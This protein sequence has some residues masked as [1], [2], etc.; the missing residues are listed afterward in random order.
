MGRTRKAKKVSKP[1]AERIAKHVAI[2]KRL[3]SKNHGK[4]PTYTWLD[5]HGY[6]PT[7]EILRLHTRNFAGIP[8]STKM[9]TK[10]SKLTVFRKM[11]ESF[12]A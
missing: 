2:A 12:E 1:S 10:A 6:F 4:L 7:Y 11:K 8:R 5:K 9:K 3:A